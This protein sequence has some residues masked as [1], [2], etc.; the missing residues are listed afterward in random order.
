[1]SARSN[2]KAENPAL[3]LAGEVF[4]LTAILSALSHQL[5]A[6]ES[7]DVESVHDEA[8]MAGRVCE[9][10][11][12]RLTVVGALLMDSEVKS[13]FPEVQKQLEALR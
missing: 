4:Q 3:D 1:M 12:K 9:D 7:G 2:R 11:Q 6:I 8:H 10:V 5:G 13:R